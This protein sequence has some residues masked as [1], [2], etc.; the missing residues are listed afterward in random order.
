MKIT[1]E[2]RLGTIQLNLPTS[3]PSEASTYVDQQ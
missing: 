1:L 3:S 2:I